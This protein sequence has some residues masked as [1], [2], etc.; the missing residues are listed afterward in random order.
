MDTRRDDDIRIP[1]DEAQDIVDVLRHY[2]EHSDDSEWA[3]QAENLAQNLARRLPSR[4]PA[5]D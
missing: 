2:A 5:G 4:Q 3:W 1:H